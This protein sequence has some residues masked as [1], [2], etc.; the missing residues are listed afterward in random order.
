MF[1]SLLVPLDG[2]CFGEHALPWALA[3]H[4]RTGASLHPVH[5]H[6]P[7]PY[8]DMH[9]VTP[10]HY[11]GITLGE[12][13]AKTKLEEREYLDDVSARIAHV[14]GVTVSPTMI[15][16][17]LVDALDR[18]ARDVAADLIIM[19]THG[20]TGLSRAWL[21]SVADGL[22]RH[23]ETPVLL[24]RPG[25][26]AADLTAE[27]TAAHIL[28]PLDGSKPGEQ[29]LASA[30][31][32]GT[33]LGSRFTL[34]Q[35]VCTHTVAGGRDYLI[36]SAHLEARRAHAGEYLAGIAGR[37]RERGLEVET[38]VLEARSPAR[39]ILQAAEGPVDLIAMATHGHGGITR[40]LLG[41]VT[42]KVLRGVA[43]PMLLQRPAIG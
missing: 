37:L 18:H 25:A 11:E 28:V 32:L 10:Y 41:S 3:I 19:S 1:R 40:V 7:A 13:N 14:T 35:V 12:Y 36:P 20:R 30:G 31:A 29:I 15:P 16:G 27:P 26:S 17:P 9:S 43:K 4:R 5:V 21:G 6:V 39:A 24:V 22:V 23:T 8:S 33:V 38:W 34:L 42:D 2:S